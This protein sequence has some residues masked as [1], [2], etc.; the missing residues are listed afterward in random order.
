[1]R[2]WAISREA[3]GCGC[4]LA[5]QS[6]ETLC[7]RPE[8]RALRPYDLAN[9]LRISHE[10]AQQA[11]NTVAAIVGSPGSIPQGMSLDECFADV[12]RPARPSNVL[13]S[14]DAGGIFGSQN[15][16]DIDGMSGDQSRMGLAVVAIAGI[17][18][19][20]KVFDGMR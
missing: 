17:L 4:G 20:A 2:M 11:I 7:R 3:E 14:P 16:G 10:A 19:F 5:D 1:M 18:I 15:A 9:E 13:F 12:G 6:A 8:L